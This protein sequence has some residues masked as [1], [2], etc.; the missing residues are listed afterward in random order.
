MNIEHHTPLT[1]AVHPLA[2]IIL[3]PL[4]WIASIFLNGN[5]YYSILTVIASSGAFSV[6]FVW[7]FL[8]ENGQ[9]SFYALLFA[10]I[11]GA[12]TTHLL[13]GSF[14]ESY[15]FSAT[16]LLFFL[17]LLQRKKTSFG[18]LVSAGLIVFGI[19]I[20]NVAQTAI[21]TLFLSPP[22]SCAGF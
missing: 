11:L 9:K 1:R 2:Y 20:S 6:F 3:R 17:V 14:V 5:I 19:T 13:F 15:I 7:F 16:A 12:T 4:V 22:L 18:V 8:K 21:A 10:A